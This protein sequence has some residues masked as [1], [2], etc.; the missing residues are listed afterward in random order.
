[1]YDPELDELFINRCAL[2]TLTPGN[3]TCSCRTSG[4]YIAS[5]VL[6]EPID[7]GQPTGAEDDSIPWN[8]DFS[9][10]V[11]AVGVLIVGA[12]IAAYV[13]KRGKDVYRNSQV[14]EHSHVFYDP[15]AGEWMIDRVDPQ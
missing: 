11:S 4:V 3:A 8:D 15:Y 6:V 13:V 12:L 1:M 5:E 2:N 14:R 7:R 9:Y 10:L